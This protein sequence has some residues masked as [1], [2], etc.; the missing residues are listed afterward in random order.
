MQLNKE[1]Y[2]KYEELINLNVEEAL[3]YCVTVLNETN[4]V[5]IYAYI[6]DCFM[7]LDN[8]QEAINNFNKGISLDC[9]NKSFALSLKA[10]ALFYLEEYIESK[11]I[12]L[13]LLRENPYSFFIIAYLT[14]I[15]IKLGNYLEGIS[16]A[17]KIIL[18][19][20]LNK[21]DLAYIETKIGWIHLKYLANF[22]KA[23]ECFEK[24]LKLSNDSEVVYVGL[25]E[26][27]LEI[28]DYLSAIVNFQKAIELGEATIEVYY[29]M[30]LSYKGLKKYED[31]LEYFKIVSQVDD[32]YIDVCKE[33]N[34]IKSLII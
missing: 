4:N 32:N 23:Y 29:S 14:D 16:R 21:E 3:E 8:F 30:A 12:F 25:G 18:H 13:K 34:E 9:S 10:E 19:G 5:D 20:D 24:A 1:F 27:Y 7:A 2:I 15:D 31:S 33:I 22:H 28:R 6:G 17:E 11:R 26:Y